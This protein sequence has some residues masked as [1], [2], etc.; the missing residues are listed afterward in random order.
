MSIA[1]RSTRSFAAPSGMAP[2]LAR[3]S[4]R[5]T[6]LHTTLGEVSDRSRKVMIIEDP[7][8]YIFPRIYQTQATESTSRTFCRR[9]SAVTPF[10]S[11]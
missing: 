5:T 3:E 6:T 10:R 7:L 11:G 9:A 1:T 8:E 4:G 2:W